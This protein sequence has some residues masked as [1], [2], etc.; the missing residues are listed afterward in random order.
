MTDSEVC[1]FEIIRALSISRYVYLIVLLATLI[2]CYYII[3]LV[4]LSSMYLIIL[5]LK[6]SGVT[7]P[8]REDTYM[9]TG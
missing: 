9:Q 6:I 8:S 1:L 5:I 4:Y 7:Y 2:M 3:V